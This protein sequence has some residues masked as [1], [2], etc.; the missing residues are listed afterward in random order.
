M[1]LTRAKVA[2]DLSVSPY[3]YQV[4]YE[5]S[6]F[7]F[8]FS[9]RLYMKKFE[10]KLLENRESINLSLSNR[11][12]IKVDVPMI[13][14]LRLYGT[15][16]KRGFLVVVNGENVTCQNNIR[17]SGEIVTLQNSDE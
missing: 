15:I 13:A 17:L 7:V 3:H 16:E 14:D 11:F 4:D 6:V 2:Y 8:V 12:G 9:S 1:K 10:E 5:G